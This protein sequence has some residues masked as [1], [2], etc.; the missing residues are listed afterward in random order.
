MKR[1]FSENRKENTH[2]H[3]PALYF[4][5]VVFR[6][7]LWF[8]PFKKP[9]CS[10]GKNGWNSWLLFYLWRCEWIS[11]CFPGLSCPAGCFIGYSW[12][13]L[14]KCLSEACK[15]LLSVHLSSVWVFFLLPS[16]GTLCFWPLGDHLLWPLWFCFCFCFFRENWGVWGIKSTEEIC[17]QTSESC[18]LSRVDLFAFSPSPCLVLQREEELS[19][20]ARRPWK[21]AATLL[22]KPPLLFV[23]L[24]PTF[25]D[26]C[27]V[28]RRSRYPPFLFLLFLLKPFTQMEMNCV[29]TLSYRDLCKWIVK[30]SHGNSLDTCC[31]LC[32]MDAVYPLTNEQMNIHM[33]WKVSASL[34]D[35]LAV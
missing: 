2:S 27:W 28:L 8:L 31:V 5:K 16:P 14:W 13:V 1:G 34:G 33:T 3:S 17:R 21:D 19:E 32:W 9:I 26:A 29:L 25:L 6:W 18:K 35:A 4:H 12:Q 10:L 20:A 30:W 24:W 7:G 22:E 23:L 15:L 11:L